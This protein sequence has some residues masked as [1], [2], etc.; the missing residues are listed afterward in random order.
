MEWAARYTTAGILSAARACLHTSVSAWSSITTTVNRR[1][2]HVCFQ[3]NV[4]KA[5]AL[6][7]NA[8]VWHRTLTERFAF[9]GDVLHTA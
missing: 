6:G 8:T 7:R 5:E 9:V 1:G 2:I 3:E 4:E